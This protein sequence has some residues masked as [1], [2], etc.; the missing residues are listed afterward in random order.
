[1]KEKIKKY[2][3]GIIIIFFMLWLSL[4]D[5]DLFWIALLVFG[6]I[7]YL[8]S[9]KPIP[10]KIS[11]IILIITWMSFLAVSGLIF[12]INH[13]LPHGPRYPTGIEV[14]YEW[15]PCHEVYKEDLRG[16]NIPKWAKFF[17]QSEGELLWM[18]LLVI[19][20]IITGLVV[21]NKREEEREK[22]INK[23]IESRNKSSSQ[24]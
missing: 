13:Y 11:R 23:Y 12:Y 8:I 20:V 6:I 7:I 14:C 9:T 2:W 5:S 10:K 18:G 15:G 22:Y 4:R 24:N 1:M 16:L 3:L 17:K 21:E 19:G